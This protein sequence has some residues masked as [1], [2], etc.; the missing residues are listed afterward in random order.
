MT[1][2][3]EIKQYI[4]Q[5]TTKS[6]NPAGIQEQTRTENILTAFCDTYMTTKTWPDTSDY[7]AF[8]ADIDSPKL[9]TE[10]TNR[11]KKF[12]A[13]LKEKEIEIMPEDNTTATTAPATWP[14]L[15][16]ETEPVQKVKGKP[17]RKVLDTVNGEKRTEKLM[18]Y[19]T[20]ELMTEI[21][22]WCHLK[23]I[24][25]VSYITNLI[26]TDL[27]NDVKMDKLKKFLALSVEA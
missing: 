15:S 16:T 5:L 7:E 27:H 24:S 14:E 19:F 6:G 26:E 17:G 4:S 8:S 3:T 21:R 9:A 12:F 23:R 2:T 25:I 22:N 10:N 1:F 11:V 18:M 13:W 20:P